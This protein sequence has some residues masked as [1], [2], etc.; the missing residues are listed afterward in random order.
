MARQSSSTA[1]VGA[2]LIDGRAAAAEITAQVAEETRRLKAEA[3]VV[4]G[5]AVIL[6][7]DDPA[8][9]VYVSGKGRKA[10]EVGFRSVQRDLPASV[11]QAELIDLV[12]AL[13]DDPAI[14][15][16]LVQLPLPD[17]LDKTPVVEAIR[18]EKDVDGLH[19]V[20][21]GRLAS[22]SRAAMVPCTPAGCLI[23]AKRALDG[24]LVGRNAVVVGRSNL[25]GKPVAQ[26]LLAEH[27]TVT[28]CHSRTRDLAATVRGGDVVVAAVGRA[29]LVRGDWIKPG[30]VVI[31]V[32]INRIAA[33]ERGEGK[34]RLVGDVAFDEAVKVAGGITPVPG[35]VGPMTIAMLMANTLTAACRSVG[36]SPP[37]F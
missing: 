25:V 1:E 26:L 27:C 33:P 19:P 32:G 12:G 8:S 29:Q 24:A 20:N 4:P 7:G 23:L 17:P 21:V 3:G 16:I 15:G 5:L 6:V 31:D 34:T 14:H 13:N 36:R 30:A 10:A 9:Q 11:G 35:G 18:P 2:S 28:I 37:A 22:G